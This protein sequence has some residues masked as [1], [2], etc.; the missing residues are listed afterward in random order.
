MLKEIRCDAFRTFEGKKREP[1]TF[2][3]GLNVVLGSNSGT[4]SIGKS[5]FLKLLKSNMQLM[6]E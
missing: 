4:N 2:F 5:T 6:K 3:E 1:I